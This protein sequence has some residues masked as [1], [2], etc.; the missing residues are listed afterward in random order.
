[1][2]VGLI[3]LGP[4]A[5]S[6]RPA[7]DLVGRAIAVRL[8]TAGYRVL[9]CDLKEDARSLTASLGVDIQGDAK[10]VARNL[11]LIILSLFTS[12]DR[13]SLLWGGQALVETL[14]PGGGFLSSSRRPRDPQGG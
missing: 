1:M 12:E 5:A 11:R 2:D 13:R 3:G 7:A 8:V 14:Q 4:E 9:G 6:F 10:T